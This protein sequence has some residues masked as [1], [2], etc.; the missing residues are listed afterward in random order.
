MLFLLGNRFIYLR[1]AFGAIGVTFA[2]TATTLRA[3][4]VDAR[5][6]VLNG[7]RALTKVNVIHSESQGFRNPAAEVKQEPYQ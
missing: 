3:G 1:S 7:Y 4:E 6:E 5:F 2:Q